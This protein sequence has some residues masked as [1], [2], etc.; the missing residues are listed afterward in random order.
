MR[1][2]GQAYR[3]RSLLSDLVVF[4]ERI[5]LPAIQ[6]SDTLSPLVDGSTKHGGHGL[7]VAVAQLCFRLYFPTRQAALGVELLIA[8]SLAVMHKLVEGQLRQQR[9]VPGV[10]ANFGC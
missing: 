6:D 3:R 1:K 4:R 5:V 7:D 10:D 8:L 9:R 2:E